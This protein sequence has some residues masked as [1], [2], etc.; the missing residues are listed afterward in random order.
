MQESIKDSMYKKKDHFHQ[1]AKK[2][3]YL[4]RSAYKLK[5]IQKKYKILKPGFRVLDLGCAPGSWSQVVLEHIGAGA[6]VGVDL[7]EVSIKDHRALFFVE[8]IFSLDLESIPKAPFDCIL[9][10]MS[11]KTSGIAVRDQTRSI[12]LGLCALKISEK[13][14]KKGGT[15]VL[16][17]LEG[18]D[19]HTLIASIKETFD[20]IERF[21]PQSTRK[22]SKEVYVI[23]F[24]R[25]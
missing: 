20:T 4:A 10:D 11:P 16:K 6:L 22:A 5:E 19:L 13:V 2:E 14:L 21:R 8:D 23:G 25:R 1:K 12:E 18:E 24:K 9:S 3:G 15:L 7:E 17:I